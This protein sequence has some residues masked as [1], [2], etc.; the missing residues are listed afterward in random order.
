MSIEGCQH[1]PTALGF[2]PGCAQ[3]AAGVTLEEGVP[4]NEVEIARAKAEQE[5]QI[6]PAAE[7]LRDLARRAEQNRAA[8]ERQP[9]ACGYATV[10]KDGWARPDGDTHTWLR[11]TGGEALLGHD[12]PIS[13]QRDEPSSVGHALAPSLTR[14]SQGE[15]DYE[16]VPEPRTVESNYRLVRPDWAYDAH[17]PASDV[18]A[19]EHVRPG[20]EH[21]CLVLSTTLEISV[22]DLPALI[23]RHES[24]CR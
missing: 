17:G 11:C 23:A 13:D 3:C 2:G 24:E 20:R 6:R 7:V 12:W 18:I 8:V 15:H 14:W 10:T 5:A 16:A 1:G 19:L 9:C 22:G 21:R 4:I